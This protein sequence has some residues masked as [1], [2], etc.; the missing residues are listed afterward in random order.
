MVDMQIAKF[1]LAYNIK[2]Q[3]GLVGGLKGNT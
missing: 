3:L 2:S 1:E